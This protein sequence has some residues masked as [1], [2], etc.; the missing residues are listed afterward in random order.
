MGNPPP[1]V[2]D[3]E[4]FVAV[5]APVGGPVDS[6]LT[7]LQEAFANLGFQAEEV[8]ISRLLETAVPTPPEDYDATRLRRLMNKGDSFRKRLGDEAGCAYLAAQAIARTRELATDDRT[9][10]REQHVSLIRSLKT[11]EEVRVLRAIYGDRLVVVGVG[12]SKEER[13]EE[14]IRLLK[15]EGAKDVE[16]EAA[17][18]LE[19]DEKDNEDRYGQ[20]SSEAFRLA[21]AFVSAKTLLEVPV[22]HRLVD[23]LLGEPFKT[24]SRDE[25]GMFHAWA[26]KFRSS[27]AGRQVGAAIVDQDGEIVA[28]GCNDVPR[29]GGGQYWEGDHDDRRDFVLRHDANDRGKF[30]M[31]RDVL[32]RLADSGW[33]LGPL[34][35][36]G[37]E[38]RAEQ[39]LAKNGPL[40]KS[41]LDDLI[42]YGRIV[43]AEMAALM[44]A[45]RSGRSVRNCTLYT[46]TYPCHECA[47]LIIA[48]GISRVCFI[49][50]YVKSRAPELF[51]QML[52][53]SRSDAPVVVEPFQGISPRLFSRVFE[54]SNR[55]KD[56]R[57]SYEGWI[58]K[59]LVVIDEEISDSIPAH[60]DAAAAYLAARLDE[61][62]TPLAGGRPAPRSQSREGLRRVRRGFLRRR[63]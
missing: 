28:V 61:T 36:L 23:L 39:A 37:P 56:V 46:T 50:P 41:Q 51:D 35:A 8:R 31:A 22:V 45:A 14:L 40:R 55:T 13:R 6:T 29:P 59:R 16:A 26:A 18:L 7:A 47:R 10:H 54:M 43:H 44:T 62:E 58:H 60:E 17:Y 34:A 57:G 12:A 9:K 20:R 27:A 25:Q 19:R 33:L 4:V 2:G 15:A 21:D 32:Q 53:D 49:D 11:A 48:A 42:E 5:V 3:R 30:G 38:E 24:P 63:A 52:H 1:D